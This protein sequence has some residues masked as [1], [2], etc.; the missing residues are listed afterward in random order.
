MSPPP[1]GPAAQAVMDLLP[2][3]GPLLA[4]LAASLVLALTPGPGVLYI[5]GR[6]LL[7]GRGHGLASVAG[8]ALGNLGNAVAAA[9]GLAALFRVSALA[10][11]L[12]KFAGAAYLVFLGVK[13][14]RAA[15]SAEVPVAAP[16][17][18]G[19]VFRE[20]LVVALL[21]PKTAVFFLAFLPQFMSSGQPAGQALLLGCLFVA[22][23]ALTDSIYALA[24]GALASTLRSAGLARR[25]G[26][27]LMGLTFIGLGLFTALSGSRRPL[28]L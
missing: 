4:F 12:V 17:R 27:V 6:S 15:A 2:P 22:I 26:R 7:Q 24:A 13:A 11:E 5:V 3:A 1:S 8:V 28:S 16:A 18:L 14:L 10:F 23:A 20:G 9:L 19:R 25:G 21:N